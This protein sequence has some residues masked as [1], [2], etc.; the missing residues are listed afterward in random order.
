MYEYKI[1]SFPKEK[2]NVLSDTNK[3]LWFEEESKNGWELVSVDY[4][5]VYNGGYESGGNFQ[6]Y[7]FRKKI[8]ENTPDNQ[9]IEK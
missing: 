3:C 6:A 9:F 8:F 7:I 2:Y 5:H 4:T 1:E